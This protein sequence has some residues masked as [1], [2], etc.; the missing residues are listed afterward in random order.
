MVDEAGRPETVVA[1]PVVGVDE[2]TRRGDLG[3]E[4]GEAILGAVRDAGEAGAA[5][6]SARPHLDGDGDDRLAKRPAA[7][8]AGF[9]TTN[10]ALVHLELADELVAPRPDH[11][12]PQ[13]RPERPG[14]L[15]AAEPERPLQAERAHPR[16]LA[17]HVPGG[18]KPGLERQV[19][20]GEDRPRRDR[21][22][23]PTG[24]AAPVP[25]LAPPPRP[26]PPP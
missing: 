17:R 18:G 25:S 19:G 7:P 6:G 22:L 2:R 3:D 20:V 1:A 4:A 14:R 5:R 10:V 15:V 9:R 11:R 8:F 23:G 21:G 13:L 26:P 12:P 16:L 24:P